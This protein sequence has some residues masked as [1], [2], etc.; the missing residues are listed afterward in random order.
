MI[1]NTKRIWWAVVGFGEAEGPL[2]G[3]VSGVQ[4]LRGSLHDGQWEPEELSLTAASCWIQPAV[5]ISQK[6]GSS[7]D[8]PDKHS[9][10]PTP[11]FPSRRPSWAVHRLLT[12]KD[13]ELNEC[14]PM[15]IYDAAIEN[16]HR[17]VI[18]CAWLILQTWRL[19][20]VVSCINILSL[21]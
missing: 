20:Y 10:W 18:L 21:F 2:W 6:A 8:P 12:Y 19:L 7:L 14:Q 4:E 11:W 5:W 17:Y 15:D 13:L 16:K 3:W 1:C 9:V